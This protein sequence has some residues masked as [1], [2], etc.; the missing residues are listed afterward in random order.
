[1]KLPGTSF[2]FYRTNQNH[3]ADTPRYEQVMQ[4]GSDADLPQ[5]KR[6]V[7]HSQKLSI[8]RFLITKNVPMPTPLLRAINRINRA[9]EFDLG[10]IATTLSNADLDANQRSP[11]HRNGTA[12]HAAADAYR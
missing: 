10:A 11:N 2:H 1:M 3:E 12:L 4:S 8:K 5:N 6:S 7:I 9:A